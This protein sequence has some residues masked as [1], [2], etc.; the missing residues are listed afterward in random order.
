MSLE[1]LQEQE[2]WHVSE[3]IERIMRILMD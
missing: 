3:F 1:E 2:D